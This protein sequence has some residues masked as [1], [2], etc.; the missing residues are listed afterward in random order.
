MPIYCVL[1]ATAILFFNSAGRGDP[2]LSELKSKAG[3]APREEFRGLCLVRAGRIN[4]P[5][6]QGRLG[7]WRRPL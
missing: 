1:V 6:T 5:P 4:Q 2:L 3:Q 7:F